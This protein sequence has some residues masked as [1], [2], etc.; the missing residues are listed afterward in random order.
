MA[1]SKT[2]LA[3]ISEGDVIDS[4]FLVTSRQLEPFR[5]KPG[6]YLQLT[7][8]DKTGEIRAFA[9]DRAHEFY[10]IADED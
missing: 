7:L 9:W 10:Q 3:D 2:Y 6:H 4:Y 5:N 1:L 8:T